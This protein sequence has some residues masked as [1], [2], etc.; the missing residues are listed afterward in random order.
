MTA[1]VHSGIRTWC[2]GVQFAV[3]GRKSS[4]VEACVPSVVVK[5][6]PRAVD[7][8]P[9]SFHDWRLIRG[10]QCRSVYR[11]RRHESVFVRVYCVNGSKQNTSYGIHQHPVPIHIFEIIDMND[12]RLS[13]GRCDAL[14]KFFLYNKYGVCVAY[15]DVRLGGRAVCTSILWSRYLIFILSSI[16]YSWPR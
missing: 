1:A 9:N 2:E 6:G 8:R 10:A 15:L 3:K 11:W 14:L 16:Y 7:D 13:P 4:K 12:E 5:A